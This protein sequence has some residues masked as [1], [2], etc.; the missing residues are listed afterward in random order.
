MGLLVRKNKDPNPIILIIFLFLTLKCFT[1]YQLQVMNRTS[2]DNNAQL[3]KFPAN[4]VL[5]VMK[6]EG[7]S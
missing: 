7:E 3:F 5:N 6:P 4:L 2:I 1:G